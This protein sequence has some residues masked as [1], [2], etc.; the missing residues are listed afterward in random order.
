M[1]VRKK[2]VQTGLFWSPVVAHETVTDGQA[3]G[4]AT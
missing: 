1:V 3:D 2:L 4:K